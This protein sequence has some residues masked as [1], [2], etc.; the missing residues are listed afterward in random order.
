MDA[1]DLQNEPAMRTQTVDEP[2]EASSLRPVRILRRFGS[3]VRTTTPVQASL[4]MTYYFGARV[5]TY[6]TRMANRSRT[7]PRTNALLASL[8]MGLDDSSSIRH[9]RRWLT[10]SADDLPP[11]AEKAL[12]DDRCLLFTSE[13]R[14]IGRTALSRGNDR[15]VPAESKTRRRNQHHAAGRSERSFRRRSTTTFSDHACNKDPPQCAHDTIE[16]AIDEAADDDPVI[17]WWD[18]GGYR[19]IVE[20]A[21]TTSSDPEQTPLEL[22]AD[23]PRDRTV[24]YVPQPSSD[25]V[26]EISSHRNTPRPV[27]QAATSNTGGVVEQHI[28][29]RAR[30]PDRTP[31]SPHATA[32]GDADAPRRSPRRSTRTRWRGGRV[33]PGPQTKIVLNGHD[34]PVQFVLE[35]G[36]RNLPDGRAC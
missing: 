21:S 26:D 7:R 31:Q 6:W 18:D 23:A 3:R 29:N 11:L 35:H 9:T 25:D 1:L 24:W 15:G 33:A 13:S 10:T 8:A 22:R 32:R 12:L 5:L 16:S 27:F 17:L 2:V 14:P 4:F 20:H 28:G 34:D 36:T 19:D 30:R